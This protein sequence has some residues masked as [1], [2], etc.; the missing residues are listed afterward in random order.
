MGQR[1]VVLRSRRASTGDV[2]LGPMA[3]TRG[4]DPTVADVTVDVEDVDRRG[5]R[6]LARGA[7]VVIVDTAGRLAT[8]AH[9]MAELK[10]IKRTIAK[11]QPQAPHEV[12]LVVDGNTG[13]NVLAQIEAFDQALTL[14]GLIVTK[15]DGTAKGGVLA[16]HARRC[17][18]RR[19]AA[20]VI[21]RRRDRGSRRGWPRRP[22]PVTQRACSRRARFARRCPR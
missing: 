13:Q 20:R 8:Q 22:M 14:T 21:W 18:Q 9:L 10:K 12:L 16:A 4:V 5:V 2:F 7:D 17:A 11:V 3:G 1:H 6:S 19:T 15:L